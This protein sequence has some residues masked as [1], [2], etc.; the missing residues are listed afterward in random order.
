MCISVAP[1]LAA[2]AAPAAYQD[3]KCRAYASSRQEDT[4]GYS[5]V[6]VHREVY[7]PELLL[8]HADRVRGLGHRVDALLHNV[9]GNLAKQ[10]LVL[11]APLLLSTGREI[12]RPNKNQQ[13]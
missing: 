3:S 4:S 9:R 2:A 12:S 5:P 8:N 10:R 7:A 11:K 1:P 13:E 6:G